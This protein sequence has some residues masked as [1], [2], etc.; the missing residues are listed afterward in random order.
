MKLVSLQFVEVDF[1]G[2]TGKNLPGLN[3][4]YL[5]AKVKMDEVNI[6]KV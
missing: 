4:S 2:A 5:L 1:I 3:S 6:E